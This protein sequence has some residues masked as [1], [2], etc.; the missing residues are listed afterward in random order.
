MGSSGLADCHNYAGVKVFAVIERKIG[1]CQDHLPK[2]NG[3]FPLVI[4][5]LS[6]CWYGFS[7]RLILN[8]INKVFEGSKKLGPVA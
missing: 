8:Y 7:P 5:Y 6:R 2:I 3:I 4:G 1:R